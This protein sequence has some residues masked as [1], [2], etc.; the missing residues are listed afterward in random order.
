MCCS[1]CLAMCLDWKFLFSHSHFVMEKK[2]KEFSTIFHTF[3]CC[4]TLF[5]ILWW[6]F[7]FFSH[8]HFKIFFVYFIFSPNC[9]NSFWHI[10]ANFFVRRF[11]KST[12]KSRNVHEREMN[13]LYQISSFITLTT[14]G[15]SNRKYE[16]VLR[17]SHKNFKNASNTNEWII[18]LRRI[19]TLAEYIYNWIGKKKWD[20]DSRI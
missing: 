6:T 2:L 13:C 16:I 12:T 20:E 10:L 15:C 4:C 19:R 14:V 5:T 11:A 8:S 3:P 17:E 9:C 1:F 18:Y 7:T